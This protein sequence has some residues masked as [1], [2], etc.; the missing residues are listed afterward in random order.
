MKN[1]HHIEK[2]LADLTDSMHTTCQTLDNLGNQAKNPI[3]CCISDTSASIDH[4]LRDKYVC[5][6]RTAATALGIKS[7]DICGKCPAKVGLTQP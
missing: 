7:T 1:I 4:S 3:D 5:F 2:S 6:G